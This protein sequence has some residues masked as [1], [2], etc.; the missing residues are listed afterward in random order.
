MPSS[1]KALAMISV[2]STSI[3]P[4]NSLTVANSATRSVLSSRFS[5]SNCLANLAL[6][7]SRFSRFAFFL[8]P[9]RAWSR[10]QRSSNCLRISA[11]F[12]SSVWA[13]ALVLT[14]VDLSVEVAR[15]TRF[16]RFFFLGLGAVDL[17][18]VSESIFDKSIFSPVKF[19]VG[20]SGILVSICSV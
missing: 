1:S 20:V 11:S 16:L 17:G 5:S 3:K 15:N 4:A 6:R 2:G 19:R 7:R 10:A 12:S 9:S 8:V 13:L 18:R 14:L